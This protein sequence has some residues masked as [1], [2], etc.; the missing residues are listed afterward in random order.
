MLLLIIFKKNNTFS[1]FI[2]F[3]DKRSQLFNFYLLESLIYFDKFSINT[4][5]LYHSS[6]IVVVIRRPA[7]EGGGNH[8][9]AYCIPPTQGA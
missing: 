3:A 8:C 5:Q 9:I 6:Q 1:L 2:V 7:L 4:V